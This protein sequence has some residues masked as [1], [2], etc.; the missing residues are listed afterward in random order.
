LANP[1]DGK[2]PRSPAPLIAVLL[3][4][5]VLFA[6]GSQFLLMGRRAGLGALLLLLGV[7]LFVPALIYGIKLEEGRRQRGPR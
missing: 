2:S 7:V 1:P 3:V 4:A 6:V 5:V